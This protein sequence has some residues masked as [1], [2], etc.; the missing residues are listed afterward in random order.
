MGV[1]ARRRSLLLKLIVVVTTAWF[2]IAFLLYSENHV[3]H[4]SSALALP[5]QGSEVNRNNI[6]NNRIDDFRDDDVLPEPA[7][8]EPDNSAVLKP[9]EDAPGEMG[10]PVVLP[11]NLTGK[12]FFFKFDLIVILL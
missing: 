1:L 5:L 12:N 8:K 4:E 10:K 7:K 6:E 11:T 3:D 2:T 9:P